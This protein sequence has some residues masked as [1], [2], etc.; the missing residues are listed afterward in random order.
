MALTYEAYRD[1]VQGLREHPEWRAELRPLVL[2]EEVLSVPERIS[3][4]EATVEARLQRLEAILAGI[5]I[6][7]AKNTEAIERLVAAIEAMNGRLNAVEGRVGNLDG[8]RLESRYFNHVEDWFWGYIGRPARISVFE[9]PLVDAAL[10]SGALAREDRGR[11][12]DTDIF[13]GGLD[14]QSDQLVLAGEISSTIN[15]SDVDR[16]GRSAEI[17]RALGVN[18][19]GFV[20]GH[21]ITVP[22][23]LAAE[24]LDVIVDLHRPKG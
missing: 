17:L 12:S 2:G 20:G 6:Q 21:T 8:W 9:L 18:A 19:R 15:T 7:T 14:G 22:A 10:A 3:S 16:A 5:A 4:L 11:L 24:R 23:Q 13:V 1:L